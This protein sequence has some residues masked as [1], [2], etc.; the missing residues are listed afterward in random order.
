MDTSATFMERFRQFAEV[1]RSVRA[2]SIL[3]RIR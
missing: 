2:I 1:F 3:G